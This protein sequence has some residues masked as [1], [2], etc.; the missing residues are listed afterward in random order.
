MWE[1]SLRRL[2]WDDLAKVAG[3]NLFAHIALHLQQGQGLAVDDTAWRG[4]T[5][6]LVPVAKIGKLLKKSGVPKLGVKEDELRMVAGDRE[7]MRGL[8]EACLVFDLPGSPARPTFEEIAAS[9]DKMTQ[10]LRHRANMERRQ[11]AHADREG[12]EP[13]AADSGT[14]APL[15]TVPQPPAGARKGKGK[16]SPRAPQIQRT[17]PEI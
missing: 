5:R 6:R 15:P 1:L 7:E 17:L 2:P 10:R 11:Q 13:A 12:H 3:G 8:V 9:I 16:G 4:A 14:A